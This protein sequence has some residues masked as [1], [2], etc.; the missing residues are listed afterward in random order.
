MSSCLWKLEKGLWTY[1]LISSLGLNCPKLVF[2]Q[3]PDVTALGCN[4][5]FMS[6]S[7]KFCMKALIFKFRVLF[8][9]YLFSKNCW[10]SPSKIFI[11]RLFQICK[12]HISSNKRRASKK[13]RPLIKPTLT[14]GSHIEIIAFPLA[15][16]SPLISAAPLNTALIIIVSTRG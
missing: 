5:F 9:E 10:K 14:L 16:A 3:T 2:P 11:L 15:S 1:G 12:Y 4:I 6:S 7:I 13:R 8:Y